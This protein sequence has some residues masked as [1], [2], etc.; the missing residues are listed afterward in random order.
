M[1]IVEYKCESCGQ[2]EWAEA[3]VVEDVAAEGV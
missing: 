1:R 2:E 3:G